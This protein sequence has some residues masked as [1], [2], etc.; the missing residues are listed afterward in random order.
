MHAGQVLYEHTQYRITD[1]RIEVRR[2]TEISDD[3]LVTDSS[4]KR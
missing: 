3:V 4:E 2:F 1:A